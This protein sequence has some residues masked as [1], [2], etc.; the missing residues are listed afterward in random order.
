[1]PTRNLPNPPSLDHLQN[2]AKTLLKQVRAE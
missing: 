2:Q 1:M